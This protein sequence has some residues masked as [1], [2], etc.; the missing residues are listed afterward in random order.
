MSSPLAWKN[1]ISLSDVP[2]INIHG[3]KSNVFTDFTCSSLE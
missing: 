2:L 3:M 1:S